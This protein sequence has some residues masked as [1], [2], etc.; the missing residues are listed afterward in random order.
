MCTFMLS[1]EKQMVSQVNQVKTP[2]ESVNIGRA[3]I[4]NLDNSTCIV[5]YYPC[6]YMDSNVSVSAI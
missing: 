5:S 2:S 3:L 6:I 4:L 1:Q